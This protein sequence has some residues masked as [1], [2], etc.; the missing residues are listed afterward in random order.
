MPKAK[1]STPKKVEEKQTLICSNGCSSKPKAIGNFYKSN[2]KEYEQYGGYCTTCKTCLAKSAID[3]N[4]GMVTHDSIKPALMKVDKPFIEEVFN[5][6]KS[7]D[8]TND[9]FLGL[10]IKQLNCYPK[11]RNLVYA[12]SVDIQIQQE[13]MANSKIEELKKEQVTDE[14]IMFWGKGLSNEDY[15]DLQTKFDRFMENEENPIGMDY[16]KEMDYK[17]LVIWEFQLGK[18]QYDLDKIKEASQLQKNIA[19]LSNDLG[20]KAI[21]RKE[22]NSNKG[23]YDLFIKK[24]ETTKPVFDL[25]RD[26]GKRDEVKEILDIWFYAYLMD[27]NNV[28]TEHTGKLYEEIAKYTPSEEEFAEGDE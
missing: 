3:I 7:S 17:K 4:L 10:Y 26:L 22:D 6:I 14:M 27:V 15:I 13:K 16:K 23:A 8:A 11:Y 5:V 19:E 1:N 2:R 28:K 24:I 12:D 21:Q 25:E 18:I 20:I 9:K